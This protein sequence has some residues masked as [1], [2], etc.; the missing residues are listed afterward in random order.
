MAHFSFSPVNSLPFLWVPVPVFGYRAA[1]RMDILQPYC[2]G[3]TVPQPY[4]YAAA[5]YRMPLGNGHIPVPM[6]PQP[7]RRTMSP[8]QLCTVGIAFY[9]LIKSQNNN[10]RTRAIKKPSSKLPRFS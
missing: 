1:G 8:I 2:A 6:W 9:I 5:Q 7:T 10:K 4:G 3:S